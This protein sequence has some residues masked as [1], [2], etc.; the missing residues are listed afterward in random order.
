MYCRDFASCRALSDDA[1]RAYTRYLQAQTI[2]DIGV[3]SGESPAS[4]I[5]FRI[6]WW[7]SEVAMEKYRAHCFSHE[8][9][10]TW[11]GRERNSPTPA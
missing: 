7:E 5:S 1:Y 10:Q 6:I 8:V 2:R 4:D 11:S 3:L 9:D